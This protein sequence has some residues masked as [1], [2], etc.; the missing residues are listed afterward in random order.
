MVV[1]WLLGISK[2]FL[3][4]LV[5][6]LIHFSS[7]SVVYFQKFVNFLVLLIDFFLLPLWFEN[8]LCM[9]FI[10]YKFIEACLWPKTW[11]IFETVPYAVEK[12]MYSVAVGWMLCMCLLDP[13]SLLCCSSSLYSYISLFGCFVHYWDKEVLKAP[14][15]LQNVYFSF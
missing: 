2:D 9:I 14:V 15:L 3:I 8:V 13:Y 12:N 6:S 4:S 1:F 7:K 10:F 11:P 5:T